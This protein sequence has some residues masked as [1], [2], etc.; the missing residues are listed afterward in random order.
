M[1]AVATRALVV[2]AGTARSRVS[3]RV[4]L[5]WGEGGDGTRLACPNPPRVAIAP[6]AAMRA[7]GVRLAPVRAALVRPVLARGGGGEIREVDG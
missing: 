6:G 2:V 3:L 1:A 5:G 7:S 4:G